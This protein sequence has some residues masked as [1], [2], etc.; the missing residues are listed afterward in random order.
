MDK[1]LLDVCSSTFPLKDPNKPLNDVEAT[2]FRKR[3]GGCWF[4]VVRIWIHVLLMA[5]KPFHIVLSRYSL[6]WC[7]DLVAWVLT[8]T[9]A[10]LLAHFSE[11]EL[12]GISV[13]LWVMI[14]RHI[15]VVKLWGPLRKVYI[16]RKHLFQNIAS[17][18]LLSFVSCPSVAQS[19]CAPIAILILL[20]PKMRQN[21]GC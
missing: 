2:R 5:F 11:C 3:I 17:T 20:F 18:V 13:L 6:C 19:M 9:R 21:Q 1:E 14:L 10:C 7:M 4:A 15:F 16:L 8:L 12:V